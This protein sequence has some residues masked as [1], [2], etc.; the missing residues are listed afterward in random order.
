MGVGAARGRSLKK[1]E[2][3]YEFPFFALPTLVS[4]N[5]SS[6]LALPPLPAPASLGPHPSTSQLCLP[7]QTQPSNE[8][9]WHK[10]C[11]SRLSPWAPLSDWQMW[12]PATPGSVWWTGSL[13]LGP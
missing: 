1:K 4:E 11:S 5:L 9:N 7:H 10:P 13:P 3:F 6:D 8:I 2:T 12:L